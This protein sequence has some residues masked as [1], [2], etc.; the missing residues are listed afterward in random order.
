MAAGAELMEI[1]IILSLL[2]GLG[3]LAVVAPRVA[4]AIVLAPGVLW[5]CVLGWVLTHN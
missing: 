3:C 4:L 5:L 1:I 2:A